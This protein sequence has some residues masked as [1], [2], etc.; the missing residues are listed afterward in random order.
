MAI[1]RS[2][3]VLAHDLGLSVVAE[4]AEEREVAGL[5]DNDTLA[6]YVFEAMRFDTLAALHQRMAKKDKLLGDGTFQAKKNESGRR[7]MYYLASAM[8]DVRRV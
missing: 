1:V 2:T 4:G 6:K 8:K 7:V 3:I 5:N